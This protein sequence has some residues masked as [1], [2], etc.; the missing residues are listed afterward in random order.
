[1][2]NILNI[3][4]YIA[5]TKDTITSLDISKEF[6]ISKK[7]AAFRLFKLKK[8]CMIKLIDKTYPYKYIIA[9]FGIHYIK[10]KQEKPAKKKS[11]HALITKDDRKNLNL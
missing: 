6:N 5:N 1:M 4:I 9:K 3:L 8:S 7:D 2:T 11:W 10:Y